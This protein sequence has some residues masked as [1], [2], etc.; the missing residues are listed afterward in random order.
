[1]LKKLINA[2]YYS[3]Y[4]NSEIFFVNLINSKIYVL[5]PILK[6]D[7]DQ[8]NDGCEINNVDAD[9]LK[10]LFDEELICTIKK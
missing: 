8:L 9:L 6:S 1:M 10:F 7:L 5:S 3:P 2:V 4:K